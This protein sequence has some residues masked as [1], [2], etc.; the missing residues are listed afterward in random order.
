MNIT[1]ISPTF[2]FA[3]LAGAVMFFFVILYLLKRHKLTV[4]YS[5]V[6]LAAAVVL[7]I[8]AIAPYTVLVLRDVLKMEMPSNAV[9]IVVL[10]FILLV[11]LSLSST[12]STFAEKER[13]MAQEHGLLERRVRELEQRIQALE[14]QALKQQSLEQQAPEQQAQKPESHDTGSDTP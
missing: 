8:F 4:R 14:Q 6:W 3:M 5:I 2:R 13:R 9:F 7:A 11:L 1:S 10:A 12:A